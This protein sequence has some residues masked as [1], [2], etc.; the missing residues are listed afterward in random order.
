MTKIADYVLRDQL[1]EGNHG[2]VFLAEPPAR[3][4]LEAPVVALKTLRQHT[5][6]DDFRR[7]ANELRLLNTTESPHVVQ[8]LDAGSDRGRLFFAMPYYSAGSLETAGPQLRADQSSSTMTGACLASLD[9]RNW[10]A[11]AARP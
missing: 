2:T 10:L 7:V 6:D 9:S 3:L 4:G 11:V 8:L 1:R 5:N